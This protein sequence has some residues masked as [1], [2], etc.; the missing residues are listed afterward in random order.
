MTPNKFQA[1]VEKLRKDIDKAQNGLRV[2]HPKFEKLNYFLTVAINAI[3]DAI[4]W[5]KED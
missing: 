2:D 3:D 1:L 5:M 4:E